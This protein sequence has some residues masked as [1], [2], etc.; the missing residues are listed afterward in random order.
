M[1]QL[2]PIFTSHGV[3]AAHE[4]IRIYGDGHGTAEI[5]FAGQTRTVTA[6]GRWEIEFPPMEYGGPYTLTVRQEKE[7]I[8]LEDLYV[9][10]VCLMAG[11][12]NMQ[13]KLRASSYPAEESRG[14]PQV[15]LFT[16][17][18]LEAGEP[19][20]PRDGW[21]V[22]TDENARS[23]SALAYHVGQLLAEDGV[24]VGLIACYQGAS[25]IESWIPEGALEPLGITLSP[26]DK[27]GAHTYLPYQAWNRDGV[28]YREA[29]SAILPYPLSAVVWYQGESDTVMEESRIYKTELKALIQIW[30]ESFRNEKLPFVIVQI[31]DFLSRAGEAWKNVQ[32]AQ[33]ETQ[34]EVPAVKTVI[35]ADVSENDDIHPPTKIHLARRIV[36][37]LREWDPEND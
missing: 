31:A 3:F 19:Y 8:K 11:Q 15:R 1:L 16:A 35:S 23:W 34:F 36:G 30:R 13:F 14:N 32:N 2:N 26:E 24:A 7:E 4:P 28:L 37:A 25:V 33:W 12:S 17:P 27:G 9:G 6:D 29:L 18:R 10:R 21:V 20:S 5:V 22:C